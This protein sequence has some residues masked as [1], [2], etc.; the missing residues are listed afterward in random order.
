M[1]GKCWIDISDNHVIGTKYKVVGNN[2]PEVN[3]GN[4]NSLLHQMKL[5]TQGRQVGGRSQK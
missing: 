5:Q 1:L 3:F 4:Q 2:I